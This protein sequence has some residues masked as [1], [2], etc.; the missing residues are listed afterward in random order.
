MAAH[1]II[2][3]GVIIKGLKRKAARRD[4]VERN[5]L[6]SKH[7]WRFWGFARAVGT[8]WVHGSGCDMI[9]CG[10]FRS[11]LCIFTIRIREQGSE[12]GLVW[13]GQVWQDLYFWNYV[14]R[15]LCMAGC[16]KR[17]YGSDATGKGNKGTYVCVTSATLSDESW[18]A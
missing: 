8:L 1:K 17:R 18:L 6:S 2:Q 4:V 5:D 11:G 16:T 14:L 9:W 10:A 13:S 3:G 7:G 15:L 12:R